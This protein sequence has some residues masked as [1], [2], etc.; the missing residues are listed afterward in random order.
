MDQTNLVFTA[1]IGLICL[2]IVLLKGRSKSK[3]RVV[4]SG[5]CIYPIKSCGAISVKK[6]KITKYGFENDRKWVVA[7]I[8]DMKFVTQRELPK[9]ALIQP[10]IKGDVLELTAPNMPKF[11][12]P[13][14]GIN[15]DNKSKVTVWNVQYDCY[16]EGDEAAKWFSDYLGQTVRLVRQT[17]QHART[18]GEKYQ[19]PGQDNLVSFADGF[20]FLLASE[21]STAALNDLVRANNKDEPAFTFTRFRPNI[22]VKGTTPFEEEGWLAVLIGAQRFYLPKLCVRCPLTTVVPESGEFGTKEPLQT[23]NK[24]RNKRFCQNLTHDVATYGQYISVGD[25]LVIEDQI[26][27]NAVDTRF[28]DGDE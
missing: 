1:V 25:A 13:L 18:T 19:L 17:D 24:Q 28:D 23:I 6:Q 21:D 12:F 8:S 15:H 5:L 3:A 20:P 26:Q 11:T 27:P 7:R 22:V 10:V 16:D 4:V 9:M 14:A 2:V